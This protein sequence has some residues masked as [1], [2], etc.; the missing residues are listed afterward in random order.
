MKK[1]FNVLLFIL[2]FFMIRT[3][4]YAE[5]CSNSTSGYVVFVDEKGQKYFST[6]TNETLVDIPKVKE[7]YEFEGWYYN[8]IK[9]SGEIVGNKVK[10]TIPKIVEQYDSSSCPIKYKDITIKEK[11]VKTSLCPKITDS[12]VVYTDASGQKYFSGKVN[13]DMVEIPKKKG[14]VFGGWYYNGTRISEMMLGD[15]V[16]VNVP[17]KYATYKYV[18][19]GSNTVAC[20][21]SYEQI[22]IESKFVSEKTCSN[23][24]S[25]Y[26]VFVDENGQKY[27]STNTNETLVD[28]PEVKEGYEFEGWYYND[29]K[30]SGEIVGNKVKVTIP[31]IVE[32][33]DSSSCP[34]KYNDITI[35][36][37][38]AKV[39]SNNNV[40][41]S[42]PTALDDVVKMVATKIDKNKNAENKL[43]NSVNKYT[44]YDI[45]LL[46]KDDN[47]IQS[48]GKVK[49]S[50]LIPEEYNKNNLVVY[51]IG[52]KVEEYDVTVNGNYAQF[53]TEHFSEYILAEKKIEKN[54]NTGDNLLFYLMISVILTFGL[55]FTINK[56]KYIK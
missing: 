46:D 41:V 36:E 55:I 40:I 56:L 30:I 1:I 34:I 4:V 44:I 31:K 29:I 11:L 42:S 25:G 2:S 21:S 12:Y 24:T 7:G 14:Y 27:F 26:V 3:F 32:Q 50:L 38:L 15:K 53:E 6:N 37:K 48:N 39:I 51:Y 8:D 47:K 5:T 43:K 23:S 22:Q 49:V 45:E 35:K 28:I 18:T 19:I 20:P 33:Y 16:K 13:D 52:D 10:V 9:I 17:K 54:P